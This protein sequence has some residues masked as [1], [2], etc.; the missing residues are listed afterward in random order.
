MLLVPKNN[1]HFYTLMKLPPHRMTNMHNN[2]IGHNNLHKCHHMELN[3]LH[4]QSLWT[5]KS[6]LHMSPY[7]GCQNSTIIHAN[8][9]NGTQK[10]MNVQ[11]VSKCKWHIPSNY[12][13]LN[14]LYK[15]LKGH[16]YT[17]KLY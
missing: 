13:K 5:F 4:G 2:P 12:I 15:K 16:S 1:T 11:L 9:T 17:F 7:I 3:G 6:R 8:S 14:N 10:S